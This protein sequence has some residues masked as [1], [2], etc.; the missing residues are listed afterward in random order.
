IHRLHPECFDEATY[1]FLREV[2]NPFEMGNLTY[3]RDVEQ[4]KKLNGMGG[5]AIIISSSGMCEAGR[6]LHHL[7]NNI[8][9]PRNLILFIGYCAENTLGAAIKGGKSPVNIF[10]EPHQVRARVASADYLS[11][12]ADHSELL[13]HVARKLSGALQRIFIVHG[14][15]SEGLGLAESLRLARPGCDVLVPERG[16]AVEL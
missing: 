1:K 3:V 2:A 16:Q 12:H 13:D 5:P 4:S 9:D 7:K 8:G 6:I 11:G 10:G 14:E 15:E